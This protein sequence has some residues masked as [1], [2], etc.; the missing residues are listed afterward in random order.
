MNLDDFK[1]YMTKWFLVVLLAFSWQGYSQ[2]YSAD[3][4]NMTVDHGLLDNSVNCFFQDELGFIWIGTSSGVSRY[5]GHTFRNFEIDATKTSRTEVV[6][7]TYQN[8]KLLVATRNSGLF[9]IDLKNLQIINVDYRLDITKSRKRLFDLLRT[10]DNSIWLV[11][12]SAVFRR[13]EGVDKLFESIN[14]F[15]VDNQ[16][17]AGIT[18]VQVGKS[19]HLTLATA[20]GFVYQST[21][22][23]EELTGIVCREI[24]NHDG[25]QQLY[26]DLDNGASWIS[27]WNQGIYLEDDTGEVNNFQHDERD[28][29]S[30]SSNQITEMSS[31]DQG[32][33]WISTEDRGINLFQPNKGFINRNSA[34]REV[35]FE[36]ASDV[37]NRLADYT[38]RTIFFDKS[39]L[40]WVGTQ[41][42][43]LIKVEFKKEV[44]E[45]YQQETDKDNTLAHR[46][47]SFPR[48][49]KNGSL[50]IGTW[51]GG[52]HYLSPED[53]SRP[54]PEYKRFFPIPGDTTSISFLRVFPILEDQKGNLWLG[55]NGGGLN[56]LSKEERIKDNPK[57]KRYQ[58]DPNDSNSLS[59]NTIRSLLEDSQG[60]LWAGTDKGL[61]KF[62]PGQSGF[63]LYHEGL[64][65]RELAEEPGGNLWLGTV[66]HGLVSWNPIL[67]G[68][69]RYEL[70]ESEG[71]QLPLGDIQHVEIGKDGIIWLGTSIGLLSFDPQNEKFKHF[72]M[73]DG[74]LS[75]PVES[76]QIDTKGRLWIGTWINGLYVYEPDTKGFTNFRMTQGRM[77][78]SFTEGSSQSMDGTMY[79]G[80][81][82]GFYSFH[83][84]S[85]E[86][87]ITMPNVHVTKV[88]SGETPIDD[89][90]IHDIRNSTPINI[91]YDDKV[92]SIS[93]SSL[94]YQLNN[95]IR[96]AYQLSGVDKQWN[97][98]T[99]DEYG[100][101]YSN[102]QP[103]EYTFKVKSVYQN[104]AGKETRM[105][106]IV[107]P[108]WFRT[109]WSYLIFGS[110]VFF[111]LTQ[112]RWY[113]K[114]KRREEQERFKEKVERE[115]EER[116][117]QIKLEFFT[118]ISHEIKTPL[119]LIKAPIENI[120]SSEISGQNRDYAKLI[121]SNTERLMRLT[122]QLLD[123]RK[124][125]LGQ[126]PI[127]NEELDFVSV[128]Q[129]V[130]AL[131]SEL[132]LNNNIRLI[133]QSDFS[134]LKALVDKDKLESIVF[135]LL[136]NAFKYTPKEGDIVVK[137]VNAQ[138]EKK[139]RIQVEDSGEGIPNNKLEDVF[140][141]FYSGSDP[142]N[143]IQKSTGIGLALVKELTSLMSG[144]VKVQSEVSVG[145]VFTI[146]FNTE[147]SSQE[148]NSIY[149][150]LN[151]LTPSHKNTEDVNEKEIVNKNDLPLLLIAEDDLEMNNYIALQFNSQYK[152]I[153][154]FDGKEAFD[155]AI[156]H[157]P[158]LVITDIMMPISSGIEFCAFMKAELSTS[159]IPVVMLTA[160][161]Q[162]RDKLEGVETGAD[163][164][165]TKPF[166][167][168]LLKVT[169]AKLI[170]GRKLLHEKYSKSIKVEPSSITIT[171]VD[172]RFMQDVIDLVDLNIGDSDFS[173]EQLAKEVGVSSAQLYRKVK[174]LTG[175]AP[176]EF[177]RDIRLKR[178]TLLLKESG[179]TI[180]EISYK[181]GFG[182][183]K[184]FSRCFSQ[185]Y[186]VSPKAFKQTQKA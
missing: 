47:V 40:L 37:F 55:T 155:M 59:D 136:S 71:K 137:L 159:H 158:E 69:V 104:K 63:Q 25:V 9:E 168:E 138:E 8:Q 121:K 24:L 112:I 180:A 105:K 165:L 17:I 102:L 160:K 172:E 29:Y 184:Y 95:P 132:S 125:S 74:I 150:V 114:S 45:Y 106:L 23:Y 129:E 157:P 117:Q 134:K 133:F 11:D 100:L 123:Y 90:I 56:F 127:K 152:I 86:I 94:S 18:E 16:L 30:I 183:P 31:D 66:N 85:V 60:N 39:D 52:L 46:D 162:D 50:W 13:K 65:I 135:N 81:R 7:I 49:T 147:V 76:M 110:I 12:D 176:N 82:N 166:S 182:N 92:L 75:G 89:Y 28:K 78:N 122:N 48:V 99:A 93:F 41:N 119:T 6:E 43:G 185:Q 72:T 67:K 2:R 164:Y 146:D 27:V 26:L 126:M 171:S 87:S 88:I 33:L 73:A 10:T 44:F 139:V 111:A 20:D 142:D 156:K 115:K 84:D 77:G 153:Q 175:M 91:E 169:V 140:N 54:D 19:D 103:G 80:S 145:T 3:F 154:A 5:D 53:V 141:M 170:E 64:V 108:P 57:F 167:T 130:C 120:L 51:G 15:D 68:E 96:Y 36:K 181:V 109:W 174:A 22:P 116:L 131:F 1:S 144:S 177:I 79:F 21:E 83:P 58:H 34:G 61:N 148:N 178:S 113:R 143:H 4:E 70:F 42:N 32:R 118:N 128:L 173:V 62:V 98:T 35:G 186:G 97:T 161:G 179:L 149:Q 151:S 163:A 101:T 38:I 124:V 14:F 107:N